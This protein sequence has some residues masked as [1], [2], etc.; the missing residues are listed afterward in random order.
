MLNIE[1]Q[2]KGLK[3][4]QF[5]LLRIR[6][7][8]RLMEGQTSPPLGD[9]S[10]RSWQSTMT[11]EINPDRSLLSNSPFYMYHPVI[12]GH[13]VVMQFIRLQHSLVTLKAWLYIH[14]SMDIWEHFWYFTAFKLY[15]RVGLFAD[16]HLH[17]WYFSFYWF[18]SQK[19]AF[20]QNLEAYY[21]SALYS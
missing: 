20:P 3:F 11:W 13:W 8:S 7:D 5:R 21:Y 4:F 17:P 2:T 9:E 12:L 10:G 19:L 18:N 15:P 14:F 1:V 16:G 6:M